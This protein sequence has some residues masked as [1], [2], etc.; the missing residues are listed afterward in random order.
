LNPLGPALSPENRV[1]SDIGWASKFDPNWRI[2]PGPW[3][4]C[5]LGEHLL[6]AAP[7]F[8]LRDTLCGLLRFWTSCSNSGLHQFFSDPITKM[9]GGQN[10]LQHYSLIG[11]NSL[12]FCE[13][14]ITYEQIEAME[15]SG[16]RRVVLDGRWDMSGSCC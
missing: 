16:K 15:V 8:L 6:C 5:R 9:W 2:V 3:S 4:D 7:P 10:V 1:E 14:H 13:R 12:F 11:G